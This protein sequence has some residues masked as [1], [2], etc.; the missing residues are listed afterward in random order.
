M[1]HSVV[2]GPACVTELSF[3]GASY[4][5]TAS[6]FCNDCFAPRAGLEFVPIFYIFELFGR[7]LQLILFALMGTSNCDL[8]AQAAGNVASMA[9]VLVFA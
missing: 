9:L 6:R 3:A 8:A 5:V 4:V 2:L 7:L 1:I